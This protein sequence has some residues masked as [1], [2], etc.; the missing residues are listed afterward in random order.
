MFGGSDKPSKSG[1]VDTL[2]GRQTEVLGD[3]S[4]AGG[5]HVDGVVKGKVIAEG[6]DAMLSVAETGRIEGDV[7]VPHLLLNG[8]I[9][10]DVHAMERITISGRGRVNG[11]VYYKLIE[12]SSGASINGQMVH[13]SHSNEPEAASNPAAKRAKVVNLAHSEEVG[14]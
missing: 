12:M 14:E 13:E 6:T 8:V 3:I 9:E 7:Q 4:F 11:N 5:L 2:V 1:A 10:G